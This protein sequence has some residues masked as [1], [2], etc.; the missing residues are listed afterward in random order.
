MHREK[1]RER[2]NELKHRKYKAQANFQKY[3][4]FKRKKAETIFY[5][6]TGKYC[7]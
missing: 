5:Q 2:E 4:S 6:Q 1:E 3:K 7:M